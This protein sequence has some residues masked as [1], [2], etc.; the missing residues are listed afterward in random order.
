M[1]EIWKNI[2]EFP[3][4]QVSNYGRVKSMIPHNGTNERILK[5]RKNKDGYLRVALYKNGLRK[6]YWKNIHRLMAEAFLQIPEKYKKI[7][8][9]E[10][11]I[12]HKDENPQNN[13]IVLNDD[14]SVN[15]ELSNIEWCTQQYNTEFSLAKAVL[16]YSLDGTFIKEFPSAMEVKRQLGF[17][18]G[19]ISSC[20]RGEFMQ[21]YGFIW[22]YKN[23]E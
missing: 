21:R 5:P 20:C 23:E 15:V 11:V 8:I 13:V 12:N 16:Q 17:S 3:Y 1:N 10:L 19:N 22:K 2:Y 9:S 6:P 4:Y 14:G 18:Q 7:P